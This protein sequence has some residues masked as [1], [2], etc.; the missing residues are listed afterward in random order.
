LQT[1]TRPLRLKASLR[2]RRIDDRRAFEA[3]VSLFEFMMLA[4]E[5]M[6]KARRMA[7]TVMATSSSIKVKPFVRQP[8]RRSA[9]RV[10]ETK[11]AVGVVCL[12]MPS[13]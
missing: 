8:V 7:A 3:A 6:P 11:A 9:R 12:F 13:R 5:G 4:I 2:A 1:I 10:V